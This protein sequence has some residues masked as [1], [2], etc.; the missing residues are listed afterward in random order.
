MNGPTF[1][2]SRPNPPSRPNVRDGER[3]IART[4]AMVIALLLGVV[5][6]AAGHAVVYPEEAPAGAYQRYTLRVPTE[7]PVATTRVEIL[8][9]EGVR[10]I[11]FDDVPGWTLETARREDGGGIVR[12][13]WTGTLPPERFVE[14][15]F[16]GVN[17]QE[18]AVLG[19][20]VIQTYEDGEEV[21]WT[22]P[23][24]S[25]TP[26]STTR[27]RAAGA[28][29]SGESVATAELRSAA[30]GGLRTTLL[31]AVAAL[32]VALVSLGLVLRPS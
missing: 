23:P 28:P 17:P 11:A 14:F 27:I 20:D 32:A 30:D 29:M 1:S 31:V 15:G 25:A 13:V 7:R 26:A 24:D 5:A 12:A 6:T 2:R 3:G 18:E 21:A 22:G 9:P 19:W 4:A 10:V 16:I 8:F